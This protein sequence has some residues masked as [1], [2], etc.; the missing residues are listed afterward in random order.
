LIP[1][2]F[3][4]ILYFLIT[5]YKSI[6][7]GIGN[8]LVIP[9]WALLLLLFII[10]YNKK[11]RSTIRFLLLIVISMITSVVIIFMVAMAAPIN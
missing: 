2:A 8:Y 11:N 5:D 3:V 10:F 1:L 9:L 4:V 6:A 7:E